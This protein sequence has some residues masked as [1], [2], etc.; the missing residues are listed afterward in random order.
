MILRDISDEEFESYTKE[1]KKNYIA[2]LII[3]ISQAHRIPED[4]TPVAI[5]MAGVPGAGKTEFLDRFTEIMAESDITSGFVR[6][7]LDQIVTVFPNYS[8]ETY[9]KFRSQANYAL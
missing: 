5:V 1:K 3:A 9:A 7:D 4:S 8:P 6:I 2:E